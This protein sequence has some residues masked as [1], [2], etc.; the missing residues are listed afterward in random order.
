VI[1]VVVVGAVYPPP[2]PVVVDPVQVVMVCDVD[3][4]EEVVVGGRVVGGRVVGVNVCC[5]LPS[6]PQA[7]ANPAV[8]TTSMTTSAR[9]VGTFAGRATR[10]AIHIAT[11]AL[12]THADTRTGDQKVHQ[13]CATRIIR[14]AAA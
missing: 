8:T 13:Y 11:S 6:L 12:T 14:A 7:P 1:V 10:S 3:D 4:V 9:T 5:A 2:V